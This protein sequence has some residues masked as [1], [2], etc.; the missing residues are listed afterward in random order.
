MHFLPQ[1]PDPEWTSLS[2]GDEPEAIAARHIFP[3]LEPARSLV[4]QGGKRWRPMLL[5]LCARAASSDKEKD[6]VQEAAYRLAPL[7]ELVHT[8]SLIHDDIEDRSDTRRGKPAAH[9]AYGTDT[10][11]NAGSWLYFEA[12]V[13]I[14]QL[15]CSAQLKNSL[16]SAYLLELRRLHLGQAMDI[17]WHKNRGLF[18]SPAEYNAMVQNKT[19]ALASLAAKIGTLIAGA[20]DQTVLRAGKAASEIG[21]GF[22]IIDD[23]VNLTTGNLGKKRG[24]DIAEGKKSLPVLLFAEKNKNE[25]EKIALLRSCLEQSAQEGVESCAV[26]KAIGLL[27]QDGCIEAARKKGAA[28]IE[29]GCSS[30]LNLFGSTCADAQLI[31]EL[32]DSFISENG[33]G[34][35]QCSKTAKS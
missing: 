27:E 17:A 1:Q 25:A 6:E 29:S 9:I 10:A 15:G 31:G 23:V 2:F 5:V 19:G 8:A 12:S 33:T 7:V 14:G 13:C 30:F 18:P 16:F 28:W 32:F 22:Q 35:M 11:L 26:E 3:L 20:D 21:T 34:G 4:G 24:D